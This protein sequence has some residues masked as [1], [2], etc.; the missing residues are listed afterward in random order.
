MFLR[1]TFIGLIVFVFGARMAAAQS[2]TDQIP[3]GTKLALQ[4]RGL[5]QAQ[6][7]LVAMANAMGEGLGDAAAAAVDGLKQ[8]ILQGRELRGVAKDGRIIVALSDF[9]TGPEALEAILLIVET[10]DYQALRD[11]LGGK[12]GDP[13]VKVEQN[14]AGFD[15]V[16]RGTDTFCFIKRGKFTLI[17]EHAENA[18]KLAKEK[19][20]KPLKVS[21]R[22]ATS[23]E[24]G[25]VG[26]FVD[27]AAV[28][29]EFGDA[30]QGF[31]EQFGGMFEG[32]AAAQPGL[33]PEAAKAQMEAMKK[34]FDGMFT[35]VEE[36]QAVT[37]SGTFE[38][39]GL[40]LSL[41]AEVKSDGSTAKFLSGLKPAAN[42]LLAQMPEGHLMYFGFSGSPEIY[43]S[44]A[45]FGMSFMPQ[46][47][48]QA[49][50][51]EKQMA[52]LTA[53]GP[54][55]MAGAIRFGKGINGVTMSSYDKPAAALEATIAGVN[56]TVDAKVPGI[57]D[58][59]VERNAAE[60]R[61][62]K[63]TRVSMKFDLEGLASQPGA[64]FALAPLKAFIGEEIVQW[65]GVTD[66]G[67]LQVIDP[68]I[69]AVRAAIDQLLD[70][71]RTIGKDEAFAEALKHLPA[72]NTLVAFMDLPA[73][74]S[75]VFQQIGGAV[76]GLPA[77]AAPGKP[78]YFGLAFV[79]QKNEVEV[80]IWFPSAV[81]AQF[82]QMFQGLG[83][84]I[85]NQH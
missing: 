38:K 8:Q 50:T 66:K 44:L 59:K 56:A 54:R 63:L 33:D 26:V 16:T 34:I 70:G 72:E 15:M 46:G 68:D 62:V 24:K 55:A 21:R 81:V 31:H 52:D 40:G 1:R 61:G 45:G 42:P 60:H 67:V 74:V 29:S 5:D 69:V 6:G 83:G 48:V 12:S 71:K 58:V 43:K 27:M 79:G 37:L 11:S 65:I 84:E 76:E 35:F 51:F 20:T 17:C 53:A 32:I 2:L 36:L 4:I 73:L 57:K 13:D 49:K 25:D 22:I 47:G 75:A 19:T 77:A 28:N 9:P 10:S 78:T 64:E 14:P 82:M 23:F 3:Q 80:A 41:V 30:I 39:T 7:R 85:P 18:A